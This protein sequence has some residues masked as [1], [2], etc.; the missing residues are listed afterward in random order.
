MCNVGSRKSFAKLLWVKGAVGLLN[1][2]HS[3]CS[4]TQA[5]VQFLQA[6]LHRADSPHWG[7][8]EHIFPPASIKLFLNKAKVTWL[9]DPEGHILKV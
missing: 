7:H 2:I 3:N 1:T 6:S 9:Y 4:H 5:M 8:P